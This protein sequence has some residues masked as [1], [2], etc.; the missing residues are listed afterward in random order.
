[1]NL[2]ICMACEQGFTDDGAHFGLRCRDA[3]RHATCV[4]INQRAGF[5]GHFGVAR[6]SGSG[7]TVGTRQ[8]AI[9]Q[10]CVD[11]G[12]DDARYVKF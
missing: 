12:E 1:M 11:G 10:A 3:T 7:R 8:H 4:E 2:T 9:E 5:T 6:P